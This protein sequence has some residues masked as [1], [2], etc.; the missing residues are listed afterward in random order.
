[1]CLICSVLSAMPDSWPWDEFF[2]TNLGVA[3]LSGTYL[4]VH[5]DRP[6]FCLLWHSG[7]EGFKDRAPTLHIAFFHFKSSKAKKNIFVLGSGN[8]LQCLLTVLNDSFRCVNLPNLQT[9]HKYWRWLRPEHFG[10]LS[11][12]WT[13]NPFLRCEGSFLEIVRNNL[14]LEKLCL[15]DTSWVCLS[16]F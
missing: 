13:S 5:I 6:N 7:N 12:V 1:M 3:L 4:Q 9:I 14:K 2:I 10:H 11:L 16:I 15:A 8:M